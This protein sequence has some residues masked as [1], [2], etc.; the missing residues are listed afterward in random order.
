M[1]CSQSTSATA[2]DPSSAK[3]VS[4]SRISNTIKSHPPTTDSE[5]SASTVG[6]EKRKK[7]RL[8]PPGRSSSKIGED[9][10]FESEGV[11]KSSRHARICEWKEELAADGNLTQAV[12]HIEVSCFQ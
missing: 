7:S 4:N 9:D 12:V 10:K 1:G 11:Q 6:V 8:Y 3:P 2:V 5:S